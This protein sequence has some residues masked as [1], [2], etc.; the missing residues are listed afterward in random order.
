MI[1]T[2][3]DLKIWARALATGSLLSPAMR[4]A[5]RQTRVLSKS[6]T[7]TLSAGMGLIDVNGLLE[8]DGAIDGY[9]SRMLYL[10]QPASHHHHAG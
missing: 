7:V 5:R 8:H 6:R 2:L 10:P 4:A 9:G 3:A 1:S